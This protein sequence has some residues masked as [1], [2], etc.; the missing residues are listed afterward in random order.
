MWLL[1]FKNSLRGF[2]KLEQTFIGNKGRLTEIWVALEYIKCSH[3]FYATNSIESLILTAKDEKQVVI[4]KVILFQKCVQARNV[5]TD[6]L[7]WC[8]V[9]EK[10]KR[11][12][13]LRF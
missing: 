4:T 5:K 3:C 1:F 11:T 9:S 2:K 7:E 12:V 6:K 10:W 13:S 8:N